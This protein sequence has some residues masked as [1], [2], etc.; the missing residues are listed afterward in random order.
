MRKSGKQPEKSIHQLIPWL[1]EYPTDQD[2]NDAPMPYIVWSA[3]SMRPW[4]ANGVPPRIKIFAWLPII[5]MSAPEKI[6]KTMSIPKLFTAG[7]IAQVIAPIIARMIMTR[8][9][10][11]LLL[12]QIRKIVAIPA[13]K[14][15]S[16]KNHPESENPSPSS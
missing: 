15:P 5:D 10:G 7:A 14:F 6:A 16:P 11:R 1:I 9:I 2:A 13:D 4:P 12:S 3:A 8:S